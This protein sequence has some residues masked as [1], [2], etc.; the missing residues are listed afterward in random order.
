MSTKEEVKNNYYYYVVKYLQNNNIEVS[1]DMELCLEN[2]R[3]FF[4]NWKYD[5]PEPTINDLTKISPGDI[6]CVIDHPMKCNID[7][8]TELETKFRVNTG[9]LVAYDDGK[10]LALYIYNGTEWTRL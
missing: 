1:G 2:D 7:I 10:G 6:K 9:A 4:K 8:V 5:V 3:Y